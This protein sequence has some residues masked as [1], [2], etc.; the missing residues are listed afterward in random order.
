[1]QDMSIQTNEINILKEQIKILDDEKKLAQIMYKSENQKTNRLNEK[2]QKL[3]KEL[4]LKEPL[5][6]AKQQLQANIINSV[7]DIWPS[8]Q[9]IFQQKY[10]IREEGEEI[11]KVTEELGKKP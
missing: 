7:N 11:Q 10:L 8:I 2:L 4:T 6:Q 5:A 3:E 1:M 9:V